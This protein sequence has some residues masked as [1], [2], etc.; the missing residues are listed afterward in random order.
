MKF[1]INKDRLKFVLTILKINENRGS[2]CSEHV[3]FVFSLCG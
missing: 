2:L 3:V 1:I